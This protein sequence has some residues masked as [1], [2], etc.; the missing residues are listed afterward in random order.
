MTIHTTSTPTM[1]SAHRH[2]GRNALLATVGATVVFAAAAA[3]AVVVARS[4]GS[5]PAAPPVVAA[6]AQPS[7]TNAV[8]SASSYDAPH[9]VYV[10]GSE[11]QAAMIRTGLSDAASIRMAVGE[12]PLPD[13]E[14][15]VVATSDDEAATIIQGINEA[16]GI[17]A[18]VG[19]AE[20]TVVDL[21]GR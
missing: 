16:N 17:R 15:V 9:T 1:P 10:V 18:T 21:R 5:A 20:N 13:T 7:S 14:S 8:A 2:F 11:E 3:G 12:P 4:D 19:L 6:A